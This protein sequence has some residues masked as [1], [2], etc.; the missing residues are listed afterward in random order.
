M[1]WQS[2]LVPSQRVFRPLAFVVVIALIAALVVWAVNF[3]I[4]TPDQEAED[5]LA[6]VV[7]TPA[8]L[9]ERDIAD[10]KNDARTTNAQI[11]VGIL[12][13]LTLGATLWRA[14]AADKTANAT[15]VSAEAAI[16]TADSSLQAQLA[17]RCRG[18]LRSNEPVDAAVLRQYVQVLV[19]VGPHRE[20]G[21]VRVHQQPLVR[22]GRAVVPQLP[23]FARAVAGVYVLS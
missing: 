19:G 13:V 17:D 23:C 7:G 12:I 21:Q 8:P 14:W 1:S 5:R 10:I 4:L 18:R 2:K 9:T 15:Q 3:V 22:H 16:A 6:Q 20:H 11:V